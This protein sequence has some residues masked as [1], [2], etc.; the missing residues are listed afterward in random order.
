[1]A[2]V[3]NPDGSVTEFKIGQEENETVQ[4]TGTDAKPKRKPGK[5]KVYNYERTMF[6]AQVNVD[7][8]ND[9]KAEFGNP[10]AAINALIEAHRKA[11]GQSV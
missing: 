8:V 3:T 5:A 6:G 9:L 11:K 10:T 1:M 4:A 7:W 2:T